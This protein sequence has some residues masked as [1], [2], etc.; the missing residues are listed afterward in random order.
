VHEGEPLCFL[1][2]WL[3]L[4][5]HIIVVEQFGLLNF[6]KL[7]ARTIYCCL[8]CWSVRVDGVLM[9]SLSIRFGDACRLAALTPTF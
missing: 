9:A 5:L 2:L 4:F 3:G 1:K 6:F 8:Q 7:T